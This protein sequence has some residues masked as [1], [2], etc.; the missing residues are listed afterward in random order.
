[1]LTL[2]YCIN[3]FRYNP[4]SIKWQTIIFLGGLRGAFAY[5]MALDYDGPF[6]LLFHDTTLFIIIVTNIINGVLTKPLVMCLKLQQREPAKEVTF[7]NVASYIAYLARVGL[8]NLTKEDS[9]ATCSMK[10][11]KFEKEYIF[12]FLCTNQSGQSQLIRDFDSFEETQ[13]LLLIET[14]ALVGLL[15]IQNAQHS[16]DTSEPDTEETKDI[17]HTETV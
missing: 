16:S 1:M 8:G 17:E 13:A 14:H 2:V 15:N 11:L 5:V 12:K 4:I 6:K 7:H 10:C 9:Q 3:I